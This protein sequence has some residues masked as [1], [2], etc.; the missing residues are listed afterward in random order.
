M[1]ERISPQARKIYDDRF[2]H[3][4]EQ[5]D[6]PGEAADKA[7]MDLLEWS[8]PLPLPGFNIEELYE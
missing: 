1:N 8:Q 3:Y 6:D 7:D 5:G 2:I 4:L